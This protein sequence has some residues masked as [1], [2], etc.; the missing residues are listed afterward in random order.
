MQ[1]SIIFP[2]II[3]ISAGAD[4]MKAIN[5]LAAVVSLKLYVVFDHHSSG[6][7]DDI[8]GS[9]LSLT[10]AQVHINSKSFSIV[11]FWLVIRSWCSLMT[12][13]LLLVGISVV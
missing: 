9:E 3:D 6:S 13:S 12:I 2:I 8:F 5:L 7:V 1:H 4:N 11:I 10:L